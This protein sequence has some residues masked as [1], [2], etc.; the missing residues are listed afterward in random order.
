MSQ[1]QVPGYAEE[2]ELGRGGGGRVI[3]AVED[4]SGQRVAIK[5]LA[6]RLADDE[7]FRAAFRS[8]AR[9]LAGLDLPH[10]ARVHRFVEADDGAAIVMDLVPGVSL[11]RILAEHGPTGAKAA[12]SVL[13]GSLLGLAGAHRAGIVHR[14]YKPE[15]VIVEANGTSMLVDFGIALRAGA[16]GPAA[17][18]PGYMAPEQWVGAPASPA[19]DI[20]AAAV[21]FTECVTGIDPPRDGSAPAW[22]SRGPSRPDGPPVHAAAVHGTAVDGA[23]G[24]GPRLTTVIARATAPNPLNR[25]ADADELLAELQEAADDRYGADWEEDGRADLARAAAALLALAAGVAA[26][27]AASSAPAA[28]AAAQEP[29][30]SAATTLVRTGRRARRAGRL[31]AGHAPTVIIAGAVT[32]VVAAGTAVAV[33]VATHHHHHGPGQAGPSTAASPLQSP[34]STPARSPSAGATPSSPATTATAVNPSDPCTWLTPADF[35]TAGIST[36]PLHPGSFRGGWRACRNGS[37]YVGSRSAFLS[38]CP[39][40]LGF[41][42]CTSVSVPGASS[43]QYL[44]IPH[45]SEIELHAERGGVQYSIGVPGGTGGAQ[46]ALIKLMA[47][48][49]SRTAAAS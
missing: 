46:A 37:T 49:L 19:S 42:T 23:A 4:S 35:A 13:K 30:T 22:G 14:D 2:A 24:L 17:G 25:P 10:V 33:V 38:T 21:T 6:D 43:A 5:Y 39:P 7:G 32:A 34:G 48:V 29:T 1:W 36:G 8:E 40:T 11:R 9:L 16:Q 47:L 3:A 28:G 20:Y 31:G 45:P 12:L 15:N 41:F 26:G 18:T 27:A 44:V